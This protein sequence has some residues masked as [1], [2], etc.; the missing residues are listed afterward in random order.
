MTLEYGFNT[1]F[2]EFYFRIFRRVEQEE[3]AVEAVYVAD[4]RAHKSLQQTTV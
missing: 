1:K 3:E 2:A 4:G